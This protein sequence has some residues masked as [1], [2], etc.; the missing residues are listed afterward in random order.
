M[1][2]WNSER[3]IALVT[4]LMLTLIGLMM[5]LMMLYIASQNTALSGSQKRYRNSLQASYGGVGVVTDEVIPMLFKDYSSVSA[6]A[7]TR[8]AMTSKFSGIGMTVNSSDA[9][10]SQKMGSP[11]ANWSSCSA[12]QQS[13]SLGSI[14]SASDI[15]FVLKGPTDASG[16]KV[17]TKIVE[18][19]PGNTD[20]SANA[21]VSSS[22]MVYSGG[23]LSGSGAAYSGMGTG[24]VRVEHIPVKFRIEVQGERVTKSSEKTNLSVLYAY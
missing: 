23:L 5:T 7:L 16:Y 11:T 9:C 15:S 20:T 12:A 2:Y 13:S 3:G 14:K 6:F 4:S 24:G 21:I 10:L 8:S 22:D 17:Y 19:L 1:R 18:T